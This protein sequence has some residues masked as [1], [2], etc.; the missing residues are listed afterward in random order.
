MFDVLSMEKH[1]YNRIR[2][3][4]L[5]NLFRIHFLSEPLVL[6]NAKEK[7]PQFLRRKKVSFADVSV[8]SVASSVANDVSYEILSCTA[9]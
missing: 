1:V 8:P 3:F 7:I 2:S 9:M 6:Q 4:L 5:E